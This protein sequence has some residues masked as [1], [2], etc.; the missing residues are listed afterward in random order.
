M[1]GEYYKRLNEFMSSDEWNE[2]CLK[3][4]K[5]RRM[6]KTEELSFNMA[7]KSEK[8]PTDIICLT[9][10][11]DL[12]LINLWEDEKKENVLIP[13]DLF[14]QKTIPLKDIQ[15]EV[16]EREYGGCI[17]KARICVYENIESIVDSLSEYDNTKEAGFIEIDFLGMN[18]SAPFYIMYGIN[19]I[20][21]GNYCG[22]KLLDFASVEQ[23]MHILTSW[24]ETWYGIQIALLHP[25]IKEVFS[26]PNIVKSRNNL[27]TKKNNNTTKYIKKHYITK[28]SI[29]KANDNKSQY[30]R[31]TLLWWV[32]G[33]WREYKSGK[34]IFV[35]GYW[36]GALRYTNQTIEPRKREIELKPE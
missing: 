32:I 2:F 16:D 22:D 15:I 24:F 31:K 1:N 20:G 3:R 35:K 19:Y 23:R 34:K 14:M 26:S 9:R 36:K 6:T 21:F 7:K 10:D 29:K 18:Y 33:H 4:T 8:C 13:S 30:K 5:N 11:T 25:I 12:E 28:D 27:I 17:N